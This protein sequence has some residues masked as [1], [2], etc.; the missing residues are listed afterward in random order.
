MRPAIAHRHAKA[1]GRAHGNIGPHRA[2]FLQQAQRQ[3][4]GGDNGNRLF[5]MQGGNLGGEILHMAIGAG[6]L[7]D[8]AKHRCGVDLLRIADNG[9]DPQR[10]GA[11]LDDGD[12]LRVAVAVD[13]KGTRLGLGAAFGHGHGFG[14]RRRLVQQAGIGNGQAGQVCNHRLVVQQRLQPSL[15]DFRLIGGIGGIP[16]GVFQD[17]ALDR[18]R[19][20]GAVIALPDQA[21]HHPVLRRHLAHFRQKLMFRQ[22][23]PGQRGG[24]ADRCGN[25]LRNQRVQAGHTHRFEHFGH[26]IGRGADMAAV[27]EIVGIIVGGGEGHLV[28][29]GCD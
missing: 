21:G 25:G 13:E 23:C 7:E 24:L 3:Q 22:R 20:D 17:V 15:R 28:R 18:R 16:G 11:G 1:L 5:G 8:R 29:P 2:R 14:R 9:C 26:F 27:G 6:I 19:G 10:A 12:G 4:V